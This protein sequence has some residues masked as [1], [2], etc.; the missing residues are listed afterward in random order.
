MKD[1]LG[2]VNFRGK[3]MNQITCS[4]CWLRSNF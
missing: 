2:R 3:Y 4:H 1:E